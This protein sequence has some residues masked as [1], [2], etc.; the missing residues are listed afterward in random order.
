MADIVSRAVRSR[1]M[2]GIGPRNSEPEL[3]VRRYLHAAGFRYR[4]HEALLP[5]RPDLVLKRHRAII[6]VH[7]CFWHRHAGC[8]NAVL[9]STN[10]SF[11]VEKLNK[12]RR[13]DRLSI[14]RLFEA[15]WRV[16]V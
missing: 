6:F 15:G 7:G 8:K 16:A 3:S 10:R 5:G 12:N 1:M 11:W 13:R 14:A 9:P 4:L 2:A